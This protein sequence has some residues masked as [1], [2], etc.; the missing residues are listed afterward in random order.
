MPSFS[1]IKQRDW[2]RALQKL[3]IKIK[4][5]KL[6]GK[7]SHVKAFIGTTQ[8]PYIIQSDLNKLINQKIFKKIVAAG[9]SEDSIWDALS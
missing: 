1:D 8:R 4:I 7:G 9:N 5:G 3:N 2:I 6:G